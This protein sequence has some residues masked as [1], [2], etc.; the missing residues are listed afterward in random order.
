MLSKKLTINSAPLDRVAKLY[1]A[2]KFFSALYFTYPI[3][4][5]YASQIITPIQVGLFFSALGVSSFI[6]EIPTGI[7]ADKYSRKFC[8]LFGT[9][10]SLIAPLIVFFGHSFATFLIAS[11]FYGVGRAFLNGTLDSLVYDH[12]NVSKAA[13]RRVN[14][15]EITYGQAGI[16]TS[17]AAGGLL[18]S[19]NPGLPFIIEA[20]A[21]IICLIL[22]TGMHEQY[23]STYIKPTATHRRHFAQSIRYLFATRYLRVTV[24]MGTLFS[25]LL[26]MCIQF[27][28]EAALI[29]HGLQPTA[30]GVLI[31]AAGIATLI[32]LNTFLLRILKGDTARLMYIS[33]G[34]VTAYSLMSLPSLPLFLLGYFIWCCLNATSSFIK[35]MLQDHIP[36]SHRSTILSGF[37]TIAILVGLAASTGTGLLVEWGHTPRTAYLLFAALALVVLVPCTLWL[38]GTLKAPKISEYEQ[39]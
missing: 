18:F 14:A 21:G 24:L 31:S 17:A 1:L 7:I 23:G 22:I 12:K 35:L 36:G 39:M 10:M 34:A 16:L 6:A 20:G 2:V 33:I 8:G 19:V 9:S 37:K 32:V 5:G 15:L 25:V 13:Y 4:Y 11:L 30:R 26:G 28:N 27:V 3:F 38:A 29:E